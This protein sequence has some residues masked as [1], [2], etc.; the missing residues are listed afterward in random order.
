MRSWNSETSL[1][2]IT[3]VIRH[4]QA[5]AQLFDKLN[6]CRTVAVMARPQR[7]RRQCPA[8]IVA[9]RSKTHVDFRT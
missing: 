8:K 4:A 2:K 5:L 7:F 1:A 9:Q 6:T 3:D